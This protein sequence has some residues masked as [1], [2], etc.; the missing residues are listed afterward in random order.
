LLHACD[1]VG[2]K[3]RLARQMDKR[4]VEQAHGEREKS[5]GAALAGD[6]P[7]SWRRRKYPPG[8]RVGQRFSPI[9]VI[10]AASVILFHADVQLLGVER[11]FVSTVD[12][13]EQGR[14]GFFRP[15]QI[16]GFVVI[17]VGPLWQAKRA[18]ADARSPSGAISIGRRDGIMFLLPATV[19]FLP[20]RGTPNGS[21]CGFAS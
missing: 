10:A 15:G 3:W 6:V 2:R 9:R 17:G 8:P 11:S 12:S 19:G 20:F 13:V 5:C 21:F 16:A 7:M 4:R 1:F 14:G 18:T